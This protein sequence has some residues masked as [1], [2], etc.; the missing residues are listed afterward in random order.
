MGVR[1]SLPDWKVPGWTFRD[2][3]DTSKFHEMYYVVHGTSTVQVRAH[4]NNT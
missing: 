2:A 3:S 4:G 1:M